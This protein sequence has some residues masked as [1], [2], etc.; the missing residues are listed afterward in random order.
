MND[1]TTP[2]SDEQ[3]SPVPPPPSAAFTPPPPP[4]APAPPAASNHR[5]G[6]AIA[7]VGLGAALVIGSG[8]AGLAF[9]ITEARHDSSSSVA[10][11]GITNLVPSDEGQT[12]NASSPA[13]DATD[14]QEQGLVYINTVV[15]YG[16]GG[17]AGTG[18]ILTENGTI[19]TNHHVIEGATSIEVEVVST[20]DTY[21]ADVVGYDD[22]ADVAVLQLQDASD[23]TPV[24]LDTS[25]DVAVG[26]AITAVGN[27]NGDGGAASAAAG[28]VT[29]LDQSITAQSSSGAEELTG[30]IEV[31][32]DVV[33]GD[34]GGALYDEDG[35]V[36]G[37]TTA[38]SSGQ[39]DIVGYAV[40]IR[41]ALQTAKQIVGGLESDTI[42]IGDSAF[43]GVQLDPQS[44]TPLVA[45]TIED[46]AAAE[47]Q[48]AAG[49]TITALD[50]TAVNTPEE[51]SGL[52]AEHAPGDSVTL[53]WVDGAGAEHTATVT[54]GTGPV[55]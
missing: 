45:G 1:E 2:R 18:M 13:A 37:M 35:D 51:L 10:A 27:A 42:H 31:D 11:P 49:S 47:A 36:V 14:E 16:D 41:D 9:A 6:L 44:Q 25:Q 3:L 12:Q 22:T 46:T 17:G 26:D 7:A 54:L 29:D 34:S 48:I 20:G 38:A 33:G 23:L 30:L 43:L 8:T 32:A 21:Q 50:G 15:G 4:P 52:I 28:V 24:S 53:T 55:G 39:A 40:P 5:R 19:L